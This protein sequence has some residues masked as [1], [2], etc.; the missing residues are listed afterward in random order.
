[1][2]HQLILKNNTEVDMS[3]GNS[4]PKQ[5][6]LAVTII[7]KAAPSIV[8]A[9]LTRPMHGEFLIILLF[10]EVD[11]ASEEC[12]NIATQLQS[13]INE[14]RTVS[15]P[16]EC[17]DLLTDINEQKVFLI[18]SDALVRQL[19]SAP[20]VKAGGCFLNNS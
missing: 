6:E 9:E 2:H 19:L 17:V 16:D 1:I 8:N 14:A 12:Q 10:D 20:E 13:I 11:S 15:E 5:I 3:K 7:E 4:E 18:L